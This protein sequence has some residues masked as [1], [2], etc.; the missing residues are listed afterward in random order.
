MVTTTRWDPVESEVTDHHDGP[1]AVPAVLLVHVAPESAEVQTSPYGA[2]PPP[3]AT[4]TSRVPVESEAT[5]FQGWLAAV[6]PSVR[7][8]QVPPLEPPPLPPQP[9]TTTV[10]MSPARLERLLVT[11]I[12]RYPLDTLD[13]FSRRSSS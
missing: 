1:A 4:A 5:L 7:S 3:L 8:I 12:L 11:L 10:T 6:V 9:T 2:R 13:C